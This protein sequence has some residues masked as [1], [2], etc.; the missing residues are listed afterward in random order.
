[1]PGKGYATLGLK[2]AILERLVNI[3]D[4]FYPGM[5]L[6]STLIIL[7]N[8][9]KR[10]RYAIKAHIHR[11]DMTGRYSTITIRHDIKEWMDENYETRR[12][13][14]EARY[15][16]KCYSH[17]VS[18]F[19]ANLFDS[20]FESQKGVIRLQESDFEWLHAEYSSYREAQKTGNG[21]AATAATTAAAAT[22]ATAASEPLTFDRFADTYVNSILKKMRMA[23]SILS[24]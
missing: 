18:Y 2:P 8:E 6:P 16:I 21:T 15:H 1:M 14:Y 22:A 11:L 13:E 17:F 9:V 10:G 20:K 4:T 3:T 7:M 24:V 19:L 12:E 23:K 5:F